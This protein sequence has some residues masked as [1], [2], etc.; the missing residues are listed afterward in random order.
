[1]P[2]GRNPLRVTIVSSNPETLDGLQAYL[3]QA[4]VDARGTSE[5][6]SGVALEPYP[7]A[8]VFFPDEFPAGDVLRE[9]ARLHRERP[10]LLVVI[11]TRDPRAFTETIDPRGRVPTVVVPKPVWG[12]AIL[13]AIRGHLETS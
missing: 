10:R 13:D 5:I 8:V 1:M 7:C 3:R 4:G 9:V 6:E 2:A 11:V 12:W